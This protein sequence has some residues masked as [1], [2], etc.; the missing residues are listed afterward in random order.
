MLLAVKNKIQENRTAKVCGD[1]AYIFFRR[2]VKFPFHSGFSLIFHSGLTYCRFRFSQYTVQYSKLLYA[3]N[4][5]W[6]E[7]RITYS[8]VQYSILAERNIDINIDIIIVVIIININ[9]YDDFCKI[10]LDGHELD[11]V[12]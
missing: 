8:T 2:S 3:H 12:C 6:R 5:G 1:N 7:S 10:I 9:K 11:R 4:I